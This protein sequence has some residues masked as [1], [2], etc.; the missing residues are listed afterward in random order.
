MSTSSSTPIY[1]ELKVNLN[2]PLHEHREYRFF[3]LQNQLEVLLI[4]DPD[5]T[6]IKSTASLDVNVG[7]FSDPP[8]LEGLAHFCEHLLFMGTKMFPNENDYLKFLSNHSGSSN[9]YTATEHTN[10]YFSIDSNYLLEALV[11][12]SRFFIDPLF[13]KT[14]Q[15]REIIAINNEN[16]KNLQN[17]HRR[18]NQIFKFLIDPIHPYSKFTTGNLDTLKHDPE[19][20]NIDIRNELINWYNN[21][22]SSNIMKLTILSNLKINDIKSEIFH[23]FNQIQNKNLNLSQIQ[24]YNNILIKPINPQSNW[25]TYKSIKEIKSLKLVF[26]I[27]LS[28]VDYYSYNPF[29]TISHLIGDET[30]GTLLKYLKFNKNWSTNLMTSFQLVSENNFLFITEILLTKSSFK[31]N[32]IISEILLNFFQYIKMLSSLNEHQLRRINNE[33]DQISKIN[34]RFKEN[35]SNDNNT[36]SKLSN[37]LHLNEFSRDHL[38]DHDYKFTTKFNFHKINH[39]L[40]LLNPDNLLIFQGNNE[41]EG[42]QLPLKEKIYGSQYAKQSINP[43]LLENLK[44]CLPNPNFHL[45]APNPLIP[46]NF[47]ILNQRHDISHMMKRQPLLLRQSDYYNIWFKP[48]DFFG[49]PK[50]NIYL[51]FKTPIANSSPINQT[52]TAIFLELFLLKFNDMIYFA[53]LA[54]IGLVM[55]RN[56]T[57]FNI[58]IQ[59]FNDKILSFCKSLLSDLADFHNDTE[60][61]NSQK[62]HIVKEQIIK[63]YMNSEFKEPYR[64]T[65]K[66]FKNIIHDQSWTSDQKLYYLFNETIDENST[67]QQKEFINLESFKVFS[68]QLYDQLFIDVLVHGNFKDSIDSPIAD[69]IE[70]IIYSSFVNN[71]SSQNLD[72]AKLYLNQITN[73][74]RSYLLPKGKSYSHK[75][76]F[77]KNETPNSAI[78]YFIQIGDLKH[79]NNARK[80]MMLYLLDE[81]IHEPAFN[82]LRTKEQLGYIVFAKPRMVHLTVGYKIIVQ[83]H[84]SSKYLQSRINNFFNNFMKDYIHNLT[85]KEF[86]VK[87]NSLRIKLKSSVSQPVNFRNLNSEFYFYASKI[88]SNFYN[89]DLVFKQLFLLGFEDNGYEITKQDIINFYDEYFLNSKSSAKLILHLVSSNKKTEDQKIKDLQINDGDYDEITDIND[90]KSQMVLTKSPIPL[91]PLQNYYKL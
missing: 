59:G 33:I 23:I 64:Q 85:D 60:I 30:D 55:S 53:K 70:K 19:S 66:Y 11:R 47:D 32:E 18:F 8:H 26:P 1:T 84:R 58:I 46:Q 24:S 86:E 5:P 88:L 17:E 69:Q 83:S 80:L 7:S 35:S 78:D 91:K 75:V 49:Q 14:C 37:D 68:K 48:D 16:N 40:K 43:A 28:K 20:K 42:L 82:Q 62:F 74:Y 38:L 77:K 2:K 52:L 54:S 63:S 81:F 56:T 31:N 15:D 79:I 21:H 4:H 67:L 87:K 61:I 29:K 36:V 65:L 25:I 13:L 9:A 41:F 90:A 10:Y 89:F 73:S 39:F 71:L 22:Y 6:H 44:N 72:I 51:N 50:G 57:G 3:T 12:F 27:N 76:V 45:P 34:F